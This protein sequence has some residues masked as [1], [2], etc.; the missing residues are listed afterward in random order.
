MLFAQK[1]HHLPGGSL[2]E[3]AA[4]C[5]GVYEPFEKLVMERDMTLPEEP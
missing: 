5:D 4:I 2:L 1:R 3:R